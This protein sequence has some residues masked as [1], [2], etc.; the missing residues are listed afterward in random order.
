M[1]QKATEILFARDVL[2]AFFAGEIGQR[3]VFHLKPFQSHDADVFF[4]LFPDP[5]LTQVHARTIGIGPIECD[6]S[7]N[8]PD[9]QP[10]PLVGE[11]LLCESTPPRPG[12]FPRSRIAILVFDDFWAIINLVDLH[13]P[14]TLGLKATW[15]PRSSIVNAAELSISAWSA[16]RIPFGSTET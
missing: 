3:L 15:E 16:T 9:Y 11:N 1:L 14:V 2:C 7:L 10:R 12:G 13:I 8:R 4:A 5:T 6:V